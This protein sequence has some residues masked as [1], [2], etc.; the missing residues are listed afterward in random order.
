MPHLSLRVS[1]FE[2]FPIVYLYAWYETP[3]TT[4]PGLRAIAGFSDHSFPQLPNI[5]NQRSRNHRI[6]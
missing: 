1:R 6:R 4:T 2:S 5:L 3:S